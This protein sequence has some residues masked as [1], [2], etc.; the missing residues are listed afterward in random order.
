MKPI[1]EFNIN[2][3]EDFSKIIE[4]IQDELYTFS[5]S[6]I[7]NESD[8]S[9]IIQET[10]IKIYKYQHCL[11]DK[12]CFKSWYMSILRNECNRYYNEQHK[13]ALLLEKIISTNEVVT[14][15][16]SIMDFEND[17]CFKELLRELDEIDKEIIVLHYQCNYPIKDISRILGIKQNTIK[18]RLKRSK[19]KLKDNK[20]GGLHE[21]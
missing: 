14:I 15:D 20:K 8:I 12:S 6:K 4:E 11:K 10:I 2:N 7:D 13:N 5:K 17:I 21:K 18:S 19:E 16:N 3:K 9:D 1:K